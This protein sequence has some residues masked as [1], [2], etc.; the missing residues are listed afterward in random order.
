MAWFA[1]PFAVRLGR[2]TFDK[3]PTADLDLWGEIRRLRMRGCERDFSKSL[4]TSE[5]GHAAVNAEYTPRT[6]GN[7]RVMKKNQAILDYCGGNGW[8]I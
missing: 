5:E 8:G 1:G 7:F 3:T 6:T 4:K 2:G